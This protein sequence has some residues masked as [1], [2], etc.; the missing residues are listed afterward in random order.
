[1]QPLRAQPLLAFLHPPALS[2]Q[3][4]GLAKSKCSKSK[5]LYFFVQN[6]RVF[7]VH[8]VF[9]HLETE[10]WPTL[11]AAHLL[12]Q[13]VRKLQVEIAGQMPEHQ[14]AA[15]EDLCKVRVTWNRA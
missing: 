4:P 1:M 2:A 9:I 3:R 15:V 8:T 14:L 6:D 12:R 5:P 13:R 7:D 10:I 11:P